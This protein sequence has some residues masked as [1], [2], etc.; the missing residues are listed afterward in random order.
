MP[1]PQINEKIHPGRQEPEIELYELDLGSLFGTLCE[2]Q[3][4]LPNE[5]EDHE[6]REA[7]FQE[8]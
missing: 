1:L 7:G 4:R 8:A 5:H 6:H 3:K 2:L